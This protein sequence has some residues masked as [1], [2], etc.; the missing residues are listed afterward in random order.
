[1]QISGKTGKLNMILTRYS[2][3]DGPTWGVDGVAL[4]KTM[5]LAFMLC[6]PVENTWRVLGNIVKNQRKMDAPDIEG[7]PVIAP[8]EEDQ[9]VWAAGVTYLRSKVEREAESTVADVYAKVYEAER[10]ELFFKSIGSRVVGNG[11]KI[12]IRRDSA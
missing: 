6:V 8:V 3:K 10:P 7:S 11:G 5:T 2:T 4:P 9:E 1:M 12:R